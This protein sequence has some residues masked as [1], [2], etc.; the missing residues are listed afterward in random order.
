MTIAARLELRGGW[1]LDPEDRFALDGENGLRGYRLHAVNGTR[2]A[3]LNVEARRLLVPDLL[4]LVSLG[5][6]AFADAG[7]SAGPPDGTR[8]LANVGVGLRVGL[9]RASRHDLLRIDL[10]RSLVPDPLGRTGW[11]VSFGSGQA[12]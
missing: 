11:L 12:F 5:V 3:V 7:L 8:R 1:R 10:A 4:H 6:A 2:N 9:G